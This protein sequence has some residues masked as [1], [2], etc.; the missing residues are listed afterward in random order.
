MAN[1]GRFHA[2]PELGDIPF[3]RG[4]VVIIRT[5]R[6]IELGEV[7]ARPVGGCKPLPRDDFHRDGDASTAK[8]EG[9][10]E[11]R[12][13]RRASSDDLERARLAEASRA[14]RF[15]E[16]QRVGSEAGWPGELIDVEPL[17]DGETVVLHG[18]AFEEFDEGVL[19]AR[20]RVMCE[21]EVVMEL[22]GSEP[23]ALEEVAADETGGG[24]GSCGSGGGCSTGGCSTGGCSTKKSRGAATAGKASGC[25]TCASGRVAVG[26]GT[27][28]AT[29]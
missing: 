15:E 28:D 13:L 11:T 25:A 21:L 5:Q 17:L 29:V 3:E 18:V 19:R 12:I 14:A 26:S 8:T 23:G 10:T 20:F 2:G 6:G 4:D 7:L 22:V 16:C 24:C 9:A 27:G 1:V